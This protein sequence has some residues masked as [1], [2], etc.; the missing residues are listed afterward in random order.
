LESGVIAVDATMDRTTFG[1]KWVGPFQVA[2][3]G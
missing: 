1:A 3:A 2:L